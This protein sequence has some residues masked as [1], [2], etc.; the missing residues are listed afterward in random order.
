[1]TPIPKST[2]Q[3]YQTDFVAWTEKTVQ[4]IRAGQFEKNDQSEEL[5]SSGKSG[6]KRF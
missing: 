2:A 5:L 1:M 3:L 4:L 6:N